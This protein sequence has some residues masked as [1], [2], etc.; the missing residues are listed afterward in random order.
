MPGTQHPGMLVTVITVS[1]P[2]SYWELSPSSQ[3]I[4]KEAT[5]CFLYND[6]DPDNNNSCLFHE[7]FLC[8]FY[9]DFDIYSSPLILNKINEVSTVIILTSQVMNLFREV[10]NENED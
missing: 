9:V 10:L 2:N 4:N 7:P 5:M 8:R 6:K 3:L 1:S